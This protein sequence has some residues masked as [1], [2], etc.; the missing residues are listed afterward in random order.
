MDTILGN[1]VTRFTCLRNK[2]SS[3]LDLTSVSTTE[4]LHVV[5][6]QDRAN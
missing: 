3:K 5:I 6:C 1:N 4:F 2:T